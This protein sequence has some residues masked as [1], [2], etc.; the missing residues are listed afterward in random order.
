MIVLTTLIGLA[1]IAILVGLLHFTGK[2]TC[3]VLDT[4]R[5]SSDPP[6]YVLGGSVWI[7]LLAGSFASYFIGHFIL[8]AFERFAGA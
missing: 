1:G 7:V 5:L 4:P 2:F 6:Y 3:L 8:M